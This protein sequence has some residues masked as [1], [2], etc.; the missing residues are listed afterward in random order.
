MVD[1]V[2]IY[3]ERKD[4]LSKQL[5]LQKNLMSKEETKNSEGVIED[6]QSILENLDLQVVPR[7]KSKKNQHVTIDLANEKGINSG[8]FGWC[9]VCRK[10]ANLY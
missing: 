6:L 4:N 3:H 10:E 7:L 5:E 9:M 2:C 1:N 8:K